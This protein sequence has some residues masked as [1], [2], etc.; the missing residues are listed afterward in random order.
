MDDKLIDVWDPLLRIFHWGLVTS[1]FVAYATEIDVLSLH[2]LA[3][4][5]VTI[6]LIFRISWGFFG[7]RHARFSDFVKSPKIVLRYLR[8]ILRG[9]A[10]RFTGHNPAGG[11]M[12]VA[13]LIILAL[14][15]IS[16]LALL[17]L[18]GEA[19]P[20]AFL[21]GRFPGRVEDWAEEIH[22]FLS[23]VAA[24]MIVAHVAGVLWG[25]YFHREN[26]IKSMISGKKR[27]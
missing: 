27:V 9:T 17:G 7:P 1:F 19:G 18:E 15:C 20:L 2:N 11:A 10:E 21:Y 8:A 14:V 6:L 13:L 3:G 22:E 4:Y 12:V 16:G 5:I 25:C 26:L 24:I 23:N